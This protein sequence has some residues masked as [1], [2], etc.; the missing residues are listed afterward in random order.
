MNDNSA[1]N[2]LV[3]LSEFR[4]PVEASLAQAWLAD[5][6]IEASLDGAATANWLNYM[7]ADLIG[8]RLSVKQGDLVRAREVLDRLRAE[9]AA[10]KDPSEDSPPTPPMTRAFRAAVIGAVILPPLLSLYSLAIVIKHRLWEPQPGE[11]R[12]DWRLY[13]TV[14][15]Q[16]LGVLFFWW[17]VFL[18]RD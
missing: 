10:N 14:F 5:E 13:A 12:V 9:Q 15:F 11:T 18:F 17:I 4:T 2:D 3:T 7:G 1:S 8:A 16:I 6:G